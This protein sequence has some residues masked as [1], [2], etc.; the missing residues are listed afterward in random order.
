MGKEVNDDGVDE[1]SLYNDDD[2]CRD[3]DYNATN[4]GGD[5][6][7]SNYNGKKWLVINLVGIVMM[8]VVVVMNGEYSDDEG[9]SGDESGEYSNDDDGGGDEW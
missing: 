8:R 3:S 2:E 9:C 4:Y 1:P 5:R 6:N 7:Y